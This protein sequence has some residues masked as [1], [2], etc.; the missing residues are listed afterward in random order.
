MVAAPPAEGPLMKKLHLAIST[1]SI[2]ATITNYSTR[3]G[4][5]PC[6]VIDGEYALWRTEGLNLSVRRDSGCAPG[7]LRHLGWEDPTA[8]AFSQDSDVNGITWERFSAN[9]QAEEIN[10]LWP[11]AKYQP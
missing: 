5:D 1:N 9:H 10:E 2:E 6:L 8:T 11:A 4:A 3:L 7:S